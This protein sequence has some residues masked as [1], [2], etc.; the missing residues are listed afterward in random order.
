M[1]LVNMPHKSIDR[2]VIHISV[3]YLTSSDRSTFLSDPS[4]ILKDG[5]YVK[6]D[7][8]TGMSA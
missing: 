1:I 7:L 2:G 6:H 4:R 8:V 3:L 5:G